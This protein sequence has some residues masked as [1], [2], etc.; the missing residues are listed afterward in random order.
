MYAQN[1]RNLRK[2]SM[3]YR[4]LPGKVPAELKESIQIS[5]FNQ[6]TA[7]GIFAYIVYICIPCVLH[8]L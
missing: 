8:P 4:E 2:K 1:H 5:A 3:I 6:K 7:I